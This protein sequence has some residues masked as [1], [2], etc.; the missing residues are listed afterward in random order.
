MTMQWERF[1]QGITSST[2]DLQHLTLEQLDRS[3][4]SSEPRAA[5]SSPES[6]FQDG[7][8]QPEPEACC[9]SI[10]LA[11]NERLKDLVNLGWH[12]VGLWHGRYG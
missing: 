12:R 4:C 1:A 3:Q 8:H 6:L 5:T 2:G 9:W 11:C 7:L 10:D